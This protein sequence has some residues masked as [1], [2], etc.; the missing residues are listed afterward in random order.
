M[1]KQLGREPYDLPQ[2]KIKKELT[3]L[4][5]IL[6]LTIDDFELTNYKSHPAIKAE[7]FTGLKK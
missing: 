3:S 2:M 4:E 7:L 1:Q 5:D 6:K